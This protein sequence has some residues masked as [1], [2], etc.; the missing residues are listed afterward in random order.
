MSVSERQSAFDVCP[1]GR[2]GKKGCVWCLYCC[3]TGIVRRV[4]IID[5]E[6]EFV[7]HRF[8]DI[9]II[10]ILIII[11]FNRRIKSTSCKE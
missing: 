3:E 8:G 9:I 1:A 4:Y 7:Q 11:I 10:T 6:L 2:W 5:N